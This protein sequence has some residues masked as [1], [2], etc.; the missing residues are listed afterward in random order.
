[1]PRQTFKQWALKQIRELVMIGMVT[2]HLEGKEGLEVVGPRELQLI[3]LYVLLKERR[4]L[5]P[6]YLQQISP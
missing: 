3:H 1:M 5:A 2:N 4:Y 6:R